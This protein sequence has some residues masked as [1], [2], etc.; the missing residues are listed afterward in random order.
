MVRGII[1]T[2]KEFLSRPEIVRLIPL[3]ATDPTG[4]IA[5]KLFR[6]TNPKDL[7]AFPVLNVCDNSGAIDMSQD[8]MPSKPPVGKKRPFQIDRI[9]DLQIPERRFFQRLL[10]RLNIEC[11]LGPF[12][13]GQANAV[14]RYTVISFQ[15][16]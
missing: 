2:A 15:S 14:D 10:N 11:C 7:T 9:S 6:Y 1:E 4:M 3:T 16:P 13:N 12:D 5:R 8:K